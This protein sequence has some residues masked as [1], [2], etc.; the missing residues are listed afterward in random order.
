MRHIVVGVDPGKTCAIACVD[1]NGKP[2]SMSTKRFAGLKWFVES[3]HRAGSPAVIACDK[4]NADET[5]SK[6]AEIFDSVLFTPKEGI[7]VKRKKKTMRSTKPSNMHE[8][9]ALMAAMAAYNVH[10]NKLNQVKHMSRSNGIEDIDGVK[11]L[12]LKRHSFHEAATGKT[13]WRFVR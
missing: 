13:A 7:S 11:A 12:V 5:V 3:I 1:L 10:A 8:R 9:D 4:K 2:V 6:L